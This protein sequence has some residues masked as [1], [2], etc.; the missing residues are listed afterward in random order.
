[1]KNKKNILLIGT[2][3]TIIILSIIISYIFNKTSNNNDNKIDEDIVVEEDYVIDYI[4]DITNTENAKIKDGVKYNTSKEVVKEHKYTQLKT[5][6]MKIKCSGDICN[7]D[8]TIENIAFKEDI[9]NYIIFFNFMDKKGKVYQTVHY[10]LPN[11]KMG[12][13]YKVNFDIP[14]D[15][16]NA[17]DYNITGF[18]DEYE[19]K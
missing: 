2:I 4:V 16:G 19:V 14:F 1:M 12:E 13:S 15:V 6:D 3:I 7:L 18:I 17:Y 10:T 11:I 9:Q 5:D 8:L